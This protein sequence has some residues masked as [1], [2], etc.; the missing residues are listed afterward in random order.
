[1]KKTT[2]LLL[3]LILMLS[4]CACGK[5]EAGP[6][7]QTPKLDTA[8]YP[9]EQK[10][11]PQENSEPESTPSIPPVDPEWDFYRG[12]W[13]SAPS[14]SVSDTLDHF[15]DTDKNYMTLSPDG[16]GTLVLGGNYREFLWTR[17]EDKME[18]VFSDNGE[19]WGG[20]IIDEKIVELSYQDTDKC[21]TFILIEEK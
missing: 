12:T 1:M 16:R 15:F 8:I 13:V 21:F 5:K 6:A 18:L 11:E 14:E 4:L 10:D 19:R 2:I 3:A 20:D 17:D 7:V 9:Q